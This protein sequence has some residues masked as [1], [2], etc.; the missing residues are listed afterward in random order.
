MLVLSRKAG[1]E[2][3]VPQHGIIIHVLEIRGAQ[4]RLGIT[5]P[6]EVRVWRGELWAQIERLPVKEKGKPPQDA[7]ATVGAPA[8]ST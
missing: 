3:L 4:V 5:A 2:V 1:E 7:V 6:Q 8:T